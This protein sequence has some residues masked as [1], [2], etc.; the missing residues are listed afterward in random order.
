M[1]PYSRGGTR[2]CLRN[3]PMKQCMMVVSA[4]VA[5]L[6]V[7]SVSHAQGPAP[8]IPSSVIKAARPLSTSEQAIVTKYVEYWVGQLKTG[9]PATVKLSRNK[10]TELLLLGAGQHF[11]MF[12]DKTLASRLPKALDSKNVLVRI[13]AMLSGKHCKSRQMVLPLS[14]GLVDQSPAVVYNAAK[15]ALVMT[16][17][18]DLDTQQKL[19]LLKPLAKALAK[20]SSPWV[21]ELLYGSLIEIGQAKAW[22]PVLAKINQRCNTLSLNPQADA[23]AEFAGLRRLVNKMAKTGGASTESLKSVVVVSTRLLILATR[24]EAD[25]EV[26]GGD[27]TAFVQI[28]DVADGAL[29]WA[30]KGLKL[31]VPDSIRG[32]PL[33]EQQLGADVWKQMLTDANGPFK[34]KAS[35]VDLPKKK[36]AVD[37]ASR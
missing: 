28:K 16:S 7:G 5:S 27:A 23:N 31:K 26:T 34:L 18:A 30:G 33:L 4:L 22:T 25:G 37:S 6:L 3:I 10:L 15:V 29:Q 11:T 1:I 36:P 35:E 20:E 24:V 17:D 12:Y 21:I 13:N 14:R 2:G 8:T 9:V 19:V 32:K